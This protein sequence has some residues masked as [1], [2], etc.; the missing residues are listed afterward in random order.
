MELKQNAA[1]R[2]PAASSK[3]ADASNSKAHHTI[4]SSRLDLDLLLSRVKLDELAQQ[5]GT[6]LHRSGGELRGICPLHKGDNTSAFSVYTDPAGHER[7]RCYTQCNTGG[8]ALDFVRRW[9][10]MDFMGAVKYLAEYAGLNLQDLG[11][12]PEESV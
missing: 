8:D 5:A 10:G 4:N 9:R 7:W 2:K 11:F 12:N 1:G 6:K 3:N